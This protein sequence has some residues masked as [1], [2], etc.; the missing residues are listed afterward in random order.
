[1]MP[2]RESP[3]S[4]LRLRNLVDEL[5]S[6]P[7]TLV[8]APAGS[9]KS[10]LL[11]EW[12]QSLEATGRP[13]AWLDLSPLHADLSSFVGDLRDAF[14]DGHPEFGAETLRALANLP[15]SDDDWRLLVRAFRRDWSKVCVDD[16]ASLCCL[17]DGFHTVT[18]GSPSDR[19]LSELLRNPL[20]DVHF[21]LTSRG[22]VPAAAARLRAAGGLLEVA[23]DELYLRHDEAAAL[24]RS[25]GAEV[26]ES[27]VTQLLAQT[28]GWVT[29]LLLASRALSKLPSEAHEEFVEQ[30][31]RHPDLFEYVASEVLEDEP[32]QR[33]KVVEYAAVLGRGRVRE[34]EEITGDPDTPRH[35]EAAVDRGILQSQGSEVWVQRLWQEH[36][37]A[38]LNARLSAG[39][40]AELQRHVGDVH[41]QAGRHEEALTSYAECEDWRSVGRVLASIGADW[42]GRGRGS[43]VQEWVARFPSEVAEREPALLY[44]QA[45]ALARSTPDQA[46]S[47]MRRAAD[48]YAARGDRRR[49]FEILIARVA[50]LFLQGR[51]DEVRPLVRRIVR[52]SRLFTRS[53]DRGL[54]LTG[55]AAMAYMSRRFD[56]ALRLSERAQRY[57]LDGVGAWVHALNRALIRGMRGDIEAAV[58]IVEAALRRDDLARNAYFYYTLRLQRGGLIAVLGDAAGGRA[59]IEAAM[60][61]L[62]EF[63]LRFGRDAGLRTLALSRAMAG[64]PEGALEAARERVEIHVEDDPAAE[65]AARARVAVHLWLMKDVERAAS[66]A[67]RSVALFEDVL[68]IQRHVW[69]WDFTTALCI[70]AWAGQGERAWSIAKTHWRRLRQKDAPFADHIL[71]LQLH[72]VAHEAGDAKRA[73]ELAIEAWEVARR[74]DLRFS[75]P[76]LGAQLSVRSAAIALRESSAPEF[77]LDRLRTIA[78]EVLPEILGS[79]V[80]DRVVGT[81]VRAVKLMSRLGGRDLHA[82][83][84]AATKD[85][86]A[87]VAAAAASALK[88]LDLRPGFRLSLRTLGLFAAERGGVPV[89]GA[90][91]KGAM[92]R[93]LLFRLI[94]AEGRAIARDTILADLWPDSD[95]D[96]A[97]NNLRVALS[98]LHDALDPGRPSGSP[99][100]FVESKGDTLVLRTD[101]IESWDLVEFRTAEREARASDRQGDTDIAIASYQR[102]LDLYGGEFLPETRYDEWAIAI[103]TRLAE[104]V[105]ELGER[106]AELLLAAGRFD[107]VLA[108]AARLIGEDAADEAGW[109]L[110]MRVYLEAG[111]R[112][113]A[114]RAFEE[115]TEALRTILDIEPG[116]EMERL[117]A[118]ARANP[119]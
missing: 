100:Y 11:A 28:E 97:R 10:T 91:W 77:V 47:M 53:E 42:I 13:V 94:A 49:E 84:Q 81:R 41:E 72:C 12:R 34:L 24:L 48:A 25:A 19:F 110:R 107:E 111:D 3:R 7:L 93:R 2:T 16:D 62:S 68:P 106:V 4:P 31:T 109:I 27:V 90:E 1:M 67:E 18:A 88:G 99:G 64:D 79:L 61:A 75:D 115:A 71:L 17:V 87:K 39:E 112:S 29:G 60:E 74:A 36:L 51:Y 46:E 80:Q 23:A 98:R 6:Q 59:E 95:D 56:L 65:A 26:D 37:S 89:E 50:L 63:K 66:M 20:R 9:G 70:M 103:R 54:A 116:E 78:P 22:T 114:L 44:L 38:R 104:S 82:P 15:G 33:I 30:L 92:P 86:S 55:L 69:P 8:V 14:R 5:V 85:R 45:G 52:A 73:T 83:L 58:E 113:A 40:W 21:A 108:V 118:M 96:A 102:A 35:V 32:P 101:A 119:A 43:T 105:R 117:A 76:L 57:T